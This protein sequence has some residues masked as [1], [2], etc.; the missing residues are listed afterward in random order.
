MKVKVGDIIKR[1]YSKYG[2]TVLKSQMFRV[3]KVKKSREFGLPK[4]YIWLRGEKGGSE[5]MVDE[6]WL[7]KF[8]KK[9]T[10]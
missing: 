1:D 4:S 9:I 10:R 6:E 2:P 8:T 7:R 5:I 3:T